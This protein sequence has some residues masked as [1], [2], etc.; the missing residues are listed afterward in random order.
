MKDKD[1]RPPTI[2]ESCPCCEGTLF[3]T[4]DQHRGTVPVDCPNPGCGFTQTFDFAARAEGIG[5][6]AP[7]A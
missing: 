4:P 1:Q 7:G 3:L 2:D 5:G 6:D